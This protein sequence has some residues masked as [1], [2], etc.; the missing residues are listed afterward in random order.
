MTHH[1]SH[2]SSIDTSRRT[3]DRPRGRD[4]YVVLLF[5]DRC[6]VPATDP[7]TRIGTPPVRT[8]RVIPRGRRTTKVWRPSTATNRPD[9]CSMAEARI[10]GAASHRPPLRD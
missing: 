8:S 4:S 9:R 10:P 2:A 1:H 7:A 6:D 3:I 5:S